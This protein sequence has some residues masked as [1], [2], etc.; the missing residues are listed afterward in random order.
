MPKFMLFPAHEKRHVRAHT[1]TYIHKKAHVLLKLGLNIS[2]LELF[3][4]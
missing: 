2:T 4:E 1:Q 3:E